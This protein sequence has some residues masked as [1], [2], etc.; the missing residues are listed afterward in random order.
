[1]LYDQLMILFYIFA[2][3]STILIVILLTWQLVDWWEED[4]I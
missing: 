3:I 1:M 2:G 4:I